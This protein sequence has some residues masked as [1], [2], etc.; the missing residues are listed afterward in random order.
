[1]HTMDNE[2]EILN[3]RY[4]DHHLQV[5]IIFLDC[6]KFVSLSSFTYFL[7][8]MQATT[9]KHMFGCTRLLLQANKRAYITSTASALYNKSSNSI[10]KRTLTQHQQP[11]SNL[12]TTLCRPRITTNYITPLILGGIRQHGTHGH[13]HHDADLI[14]SLKSSS[15]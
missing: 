4:K 6:T 12:I 13:H 10:L 1:M 11:S 2:F 15:K 3:H 14:A 7:K 5:A 8:H 9:T